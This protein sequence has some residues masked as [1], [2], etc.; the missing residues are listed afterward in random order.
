MKAVQLSLQKFNQHPQTSNQDPSVIQRSRAIIQ[1]PSP[2]IQRSR[3]IIQQPSPIIQRP[4]NVPKQAQNIP[5]QAEVVPKQ[6]EVVASPT[7]NDYNW[8]KNAFE[9]YWNVENI[10]PVSIETPTTAI[11]LF[12]SFYNHKCPKRNGEIKKCILYN[13]SLSGV[14]VFVLVDK[15]TTH[16]FNLPNIKIIRRSSAD[17][18][19]FSEILDVIRLH[20]SKTDINAIINSDIALSSSFLKSFLLGNNTVM[21]ITRHEVNMKMLSGNLTSVFMTEN[22]T[23]TPSNPGSHDMWVFRGHAENIVMDYY[24]GIPGCDNMVVSEFHKHKYTIINPALR[25]KI[26]HIHEEQNSSNTYPFTYLSLP[27][28]KLYMVEII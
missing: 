8:W 4:R 7:V 19:K 23:N 28:F 3:A 1:Q 6:A 9:K 16:T 24:M 5:K 15:N 14:T 21:C 17:R 22:T 13:A 27:D 2:I 10:I 11:N 18:I 20:T 26:Y 25:H 12:V